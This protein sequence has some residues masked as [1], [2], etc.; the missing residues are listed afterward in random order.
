MKHIKTWRK[1][2]VLALGIA[3]LGTAYAS[4]QSADVVKAREDA[5]KSFG[6]NNRAIAAY[7]G[8]TGDKTA[9]STAAQSIADTATK[10]S[11]VTMWPKGTSS[12]DMPGV[13]LAKAQ[14]FADG[15]T[16][17]GRFTVLA[18]D[19]NKVVA[20]INTG[21]PD[22]VKAAQAAMGKNCGACHS[23]YREPL[24]PPAPKP[25]G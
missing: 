3:A 16:F 23:T 22:D 5:M 9:A 6:A 1:A 20:A 8:G 7:A 2:A 15:P 10:L 4:A 21:T 14:V 13:S 17:T 19:A 25:A 24:P 18:S 12:T 11:A